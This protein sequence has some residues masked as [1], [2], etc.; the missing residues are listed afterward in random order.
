[1]GLYFLCNLIKS[2]INSE[3]NFNGIITILGHASFTSKTYYFHQYTSHIPE[4]L[5]MGEYFYKGK[6]ETKGMNDN[7]LKCYTYIYV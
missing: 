7:R 3:E 5:R 6:N 1:M 4:M 2:Y